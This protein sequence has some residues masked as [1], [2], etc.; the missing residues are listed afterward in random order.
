MQWDSKAASFEGVA[1]LYFS[2][3]QDFFRSY[4]RSLKNIPWTENVLCSPYLGTATNSWKNS[5]SYAHQARIEA[6][7]IR[8]TSLIYTRRTYT[9]VTDI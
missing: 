6:T 3:G 7:W 8:Y 5:V 1:L 2:F 4:Y 9:V